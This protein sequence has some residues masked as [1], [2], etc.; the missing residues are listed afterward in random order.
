MLLRRNHDVGDADFLFLAQ[1]LP[2][3]GVNLFA[4]G[5]GR[6]EIGLFKILRRHRTDVDKVQELDGLRCLRM[7]PA[8]FVLAEDRVF[9]FGVSQPLDDIFLADLFAGDLVHPL[10]TH[11]R[12]VALVQP[13]EIQSLLLGRRIQGHRDIDQPEADGAFPKCVWHGIPCDIGKA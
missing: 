10:V 7:V 2:Q 4:L 9:A 3:Q 12:H 11:R 13:I 5:R 1:S 8:Y 6:Q